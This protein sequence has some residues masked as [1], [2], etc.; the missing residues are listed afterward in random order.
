MPTFCGPPSYVREQRVGED[1]EE[2]RDEDTEAKASGVLEGSL[3][4]KDNY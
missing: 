1:V 3:S 2:Q 4:I